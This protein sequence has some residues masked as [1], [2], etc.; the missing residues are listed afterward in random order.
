ME[1]AADMAT[2]ADMGATKSMK[3]LRTRTYQFDE[4][5]PIRAGFD[6][7]GNRFVVAV[8]VVRALG[9][10]NKTAPQLLRML[11][12]K[13]EL[14]VV[15]HLHS[16]YWCKAMCLMKDQLWQLL[17]RRCF[18][19][20][21]A[22]WLM[23]FVMGDSEAEAA[24][25]GALLNGIKID[26]VQESSSFIDELKKREERE[27]K[28]KKREASYIQ[29]TPDAHIAESFVARFN[30]DISVRVVVEPDGQRLI[31]LIDLGRAL[32]YASSNALLDFLK[33]EGLP[34]IHRTVLFST[35]KAG[36]AKTGCATKEV[37]EVI[38][39]KK[40]R[41]IDLYVW[42]MSYVF[43]Q[44]GMPKREETT[45]RD[46]ALP[47]SSMKISASANPEIAEKLLGLFENIAAS[48]SE[49]KAILG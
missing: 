48:L 11:G 14:R 4:N 33:H 7:D 12:I 43:G 35:R 23:N 1:K 30:D 45:S 10:G 19:R 34:V 3:I 15:K 20:E 21:F 16:D 39:K 40:C 9:Y 8:D 26:D 27:T 38:L 44:T 24:L 25:D 47:P 18:N 17:S 13:A 31:P 29:T 22:D 46:E 5:T 2:N 28:R 32:G 42:I 6:V 36:T 49:I 37:A 41:S